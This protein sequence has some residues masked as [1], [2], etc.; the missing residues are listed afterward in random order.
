MMGKFF[1]WIQE[2]I[3]HWIKPATSVLT[4]GI[5]SERSRHPALSGNDSDFHPQWAETKL[6]VKPNRVISR[7][8][9][10]IS[11]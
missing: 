8:Y 6:E 1:D 7:V 10:P 5:L 9:H 11:A 4:S 2:R 3:K